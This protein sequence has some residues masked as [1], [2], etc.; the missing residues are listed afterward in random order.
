MIPAWPVW[1]EKICKQFGYNP[2]EDHAAAVI[3]N[4]I[5][6]YFDLDMLHNI[7]NNKTVL[8]VGAGPSLL[9]VIP[10]IRN[11]SMPIIAADSALQTLIRYKIT[12]DIV[13]TDLD[14]Q[15][16]CM[17]SLADSS[18]IFVVHAHGNNMD[19]LSMSRAFRRCLGTTQNR[20]FG[21]LHNFGGFTDG[22]RM[23]FLASYF[24][25]RSIILCGMDLNGP[26]STWSI[27]DSADTTVAAKLSKLHMAA[28]L[29][30]WL[31][32]NSHSRMYTLSCDVRGFTQITSDIKNI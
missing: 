13:V 29:L 19:R 32:Q 22:D 3:L 2:D 12:P 10:T 24:K 14:G 26:V 4:D 9:S 17:M 31:A 20:P 23:V 11:F 27:P 30:E 21:K 15:L 8:C 5:L 7:I 6:E 18:I 16:D 28:S 1:Y 25:A